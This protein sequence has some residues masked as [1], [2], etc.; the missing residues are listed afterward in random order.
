MPRPSRAITLVGQQFGRLRVVGAR[1][2][3]SNGRAGWVC[4]C[5]CECDPT[6]EVI[7][8][9]WNLAGRNKVRSCGCL[10]ADALRKTATKHG[11]V[12]GGKPTPEYT[13]WRKML[14]RCYAPNSSSY[15]NYGAKGVHVCDRWR[16]SFEA[17]LA[18]VGLKP[19]PEFSLEREDRA[20]DYGPGNA[21]WGT[22]REQGSNKSNNHYIVAGGQRFTLATWARVLGVS[23]ATILRRLEKGWPPEA[24][25]TIP[26][27]GRWP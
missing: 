27:N 10:R 6:R 1:Q 19:T 22:P 5:T 7:C 3:A 18:D 21:R 4:L 14:E 20:C 8:A 13:A 11:A 15:K 9:P 16:T 24:A 2:Q 26:K 17:F 25:V 12:K 23:H